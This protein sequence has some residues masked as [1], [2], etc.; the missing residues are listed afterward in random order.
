DFGRAIAFHAAAVLV[1][2][3]VGAVLV[4]ALPRAFGIAWALLAVAFLFDMFGP[5]FD[6]PEAALAASPFRAASGALSADADPMPVTICAAVAAVLFAAASIA[7]RRRDLRA[8]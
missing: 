3:A 6:P 2:C 4:A 5:L 1:F 8:G 7:F